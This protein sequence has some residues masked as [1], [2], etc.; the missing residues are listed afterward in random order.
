MARWEPVL[1]EV[2]RERYP[3]LVARA[4]LMT[5]SVAQAEDLVQE[6]LIS[7]FA[8]RARFESVAQAEAYV[9][10]AIVSRSIDAGRRAVARE[11]SSLPGRVR[12]GAPHRGAGARPDR[13]RRRA[14]AALPERDGPAWCC[15]TSR[16]CPCGRRPAARLSEGAVKRYVRRV[17]A[18][19]VALGAEPPEDGDVVEGR[20]T[21]G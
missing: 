20:R 13:R 3:R 17:A 1:D 5:G 11:P 2:V 10:R 4:V 8:G 18:L 6:A 7:T 21:D 14:L 12:A 15:G 9:R 16:T 19:T